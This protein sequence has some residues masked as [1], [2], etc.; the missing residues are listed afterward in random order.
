M[1]KELNKKEQK[2]IIEYCNDNEEYCED[3]NDIIEQYLNIEKDT[4]YVPEE[5]LDNIVSKMTELEDY[6]EIEL[7]N[8]I[9]DRDLVEEF[10]KSQLQESLND[11]ELNMYLIKSLADFDTYNG[12]FYDYW[13]VS[14]LSAPYF[15][16]LDYKMLGVLIEDLI[17]K[18]K[19]KIEEKGVWE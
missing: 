9:Y 12:E 15:E 18:I 7:C 17:W 14:T 8:R 1:I 10:A 3:L 13:F 11:N 5:I 6:F 16:V 19:D 4:K 2:A